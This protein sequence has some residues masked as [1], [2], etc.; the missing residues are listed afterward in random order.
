MPGPP[1]AR[2]R[3]TSGWL[4]SWPESATVGSAIQPMMSSGAPAFTAAS[5][6]IRA[7]STV[8]FLARGWGLKMMPLRVLS[9][10]S[11]LKIAVE[12]GLVV[13]TMPAITPTGSATFAMP[14]ASFSSIT[15][16][17]FMS[18]YLL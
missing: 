4:I 7:A 11:D 15:P 12:V 14:I 8:H 1:V 5:S 18:R 13:G 2:I 3:L 6:T 9:A 10:S 17:V 16:Q